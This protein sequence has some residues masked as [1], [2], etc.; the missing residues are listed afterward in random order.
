MH[1]GV[2]EGDQGIVRPVLGKQRAGADW[3]A[4]ASDLC[5]VQ[6]VSLDT[7]HGGVAGTQAWKTVEADLNDCFWVYFLSR[8]S[9]K[10]KRKPRN[11]Y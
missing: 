9:M 7:Q 8:R 4:A 5:L 10:T 1:S 3:P 2:V 11:W 6:R